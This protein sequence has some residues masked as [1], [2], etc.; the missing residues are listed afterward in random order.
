M[1]RT[2]INQTLEPLSSSISY[3]HII[4]SRSRYILRNVISRKRL[5]HSLRTRINRYLIQ[6]PGIHGIERI[7]SNITVKVDVVRISNRIPLD[8]TTYARIVVSPTI[9]VHSQFFIILTWRKSA[10]T[11]LAA[12]SKRQGLFSVF[13]GRWT[14]CDRCVC[15]VRLS[16]FYSK[17][18]PDSRPVTR[19]KMVLWTGIGQKHK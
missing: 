11:V 15:L 8:E 18:G 3:N 7:I 19:V 4:Q 10:R 16:R 1:T 14:G 9:V 12:K 13:D 5:S 17:T 6:P 2:H